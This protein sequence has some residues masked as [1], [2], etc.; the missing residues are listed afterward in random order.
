MKI[1][2][3]GMGW[4]GSSIAASVLRRGVATELWLNDIR[5]ELAQH[6]RQFGI[7]EVGIDEQDIEVGGFADAAHGVTAGM[8]DDRLKTGLLDG[9]GSGLDAV[10]VEIGHQGFRRGI[11]CQ[12]P[13]QD[14]DD[15]GRR[16][17][18][19]RTGDS[20]QGISGSHLHPAV[21]VIQ[22]PNE[23]G[24]A[25]AGRPGCSSS[26]RSTWTSF[27]SRSPRCSGCWE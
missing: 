18:R 11:G 9:G 2:I 17:R 21:R 16:K 12:G 26:R 7:G 5:P 6:I 1:G 23:G 4:V 22:S 15:P 13:P 10:P 25:V 24:M 8:D 19:R 27:R 20:Q 3:I 14:L